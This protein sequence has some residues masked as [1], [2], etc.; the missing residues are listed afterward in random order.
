MLTLTL[1]D[2]FLLGRDKTA[3]FWVIAF[4]LAFGLIYGAIIGDHAG[5]RAKMGI[6]LV[7]ED[8]SPTSIALADK[9]TQHASVRL[10]TSLA[11]GQTF[12]GESAAQQVR[13]GDLIAYL[14]LRPGFG[15]S[16]RSFGLQGKKIEL[17]IDPSRQAEA[18]F[19]QGVVM[20][21][22][23]SL[24]ADR[25]TN[26]EE[27]R[28]WLK[29]GQKGIEDARDLTG[30]QKQIVSEF[31]AILDGFVPKLPGAI[32]P[33]EG[34]LFGG[35]K[36]DVLPVTFDR[37]RPRSAFEITFPCSI[38]WAVLS[39]MLTFTMS[40]VTEQKQGTLLRLR[41]APMSMMQILGGKGLACF[42]SC[43]G[44]ASLL[45]FVGVAFLGV[46]VSS[47]AYLLTA[48]AAMCVCFSGLMMLLSVLGRNEQ[49][50]SGS[51]SAIM[52]TMG[53]LGGAL[54]PLLFMPEWML[55]VSHFIPVK[56]AILALE[57][58]IWRGFN[59][60]DMLLPCGILL[61]VGVLSFGLGVR[62]LARRAF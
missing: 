57:G 40:I 29:V 11:D 54:L 17:G 50:V 60:A 6:A 16:L 28:K 7:D 61:A 39:C 15:E 59:L 44:S 30:A 34:G 3:L 47:W 9:L 31:F 36:L 19:F 23:F 22:T 10:V 41:V 42:L 20:E 37:T 27:M 26:P 58:A 14:L 46:R 52:I 5:R 13:R 35:L 55:T 4:P 49:A 32:I 25:F 43:A 62:V 56:W 51:G 18:G 33:S 21:A 45:L 53:M 12:D 24:L 1:K 2:L 48:V 38:L 8:K